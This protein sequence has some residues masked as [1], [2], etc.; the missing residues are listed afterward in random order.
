MFCLNVTLAYITLAFKRYFSSELLKFWT[1]NTCFEEQWQ[2]NDGVGNKKIL[3]NHLGN[4]FYRY[5]F[6]KGYI[7]VFV[8][9]SWHD[10]SIMSI[11]MDGEG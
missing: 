7:V 10:A 5:G 9:T 8:F 2:E 3:L 6:T 11:A 4:G 1:I